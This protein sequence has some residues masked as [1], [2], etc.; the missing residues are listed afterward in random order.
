[1]NG[2]RGAEGRNGGAPKKGLAFSSFRDVGAG[3][4]EKKVWLCL[5]FGTG[6][7]GVAAAIVCCQPSLL[8]STDRAEKSALRGLARTKS[9]KRFKKGMQGFRM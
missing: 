8:L 7:P 9:F 3:G 4:S 1:M 5:R 2:G 6:V